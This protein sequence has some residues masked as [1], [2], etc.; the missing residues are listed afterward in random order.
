MAMGCE[1]EA[2]GTVTLPFIRVT[3]LPDACPPTV[4]PLDELE[5][6][7]PVE[8]AVVARPRTRH[9]HDAA[10]GRRRADCIAWEDGARGITALRRV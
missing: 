8:V 5:P 7:E 4:D 3:D 9:F 2:V 10:G 1:E 6:D